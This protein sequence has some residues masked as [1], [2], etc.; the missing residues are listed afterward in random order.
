VHGVETV[1]QWS[2]ENLGLC[3]LGDVGAVVGAT[4]PAELQHLRKLISEVPFLV[5]GFGSQGGAAQDVAAA[6]RDDG[7]GAIINS[8][9]GIIFSFKP[10]DPKW[11]LD[12]EAAARETI[13]SLARNTPM[14]S[15][16]TDEHG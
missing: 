11:E 1:G 4:Y 12:V 6:F 5:P 2:R 9:R 15:L 14:K 3:G 8:S 16:A 10:A 13:S 7:F